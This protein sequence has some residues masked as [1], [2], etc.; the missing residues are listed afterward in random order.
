V[1][2]NANGVFFFFFSD[3]VKQMGTRRTKRKEKM[4]THNEYH[5]THVAESLECVFHEFT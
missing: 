5:L 2:I 1:S 4:D 3:T